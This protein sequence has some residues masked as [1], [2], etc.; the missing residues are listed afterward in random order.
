MSTNASASAARSPSNVN[1][2][3]EYDHVRD[4][5]SPSRGLMGGL[6]STG[7]FTRRASTEQ[8]AAAVA[9]QDVETGVAQRAPSYYNDPL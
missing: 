6:F 1:K 5:Q 4:R 2:S 8:Q 3:G 7:M 9:N